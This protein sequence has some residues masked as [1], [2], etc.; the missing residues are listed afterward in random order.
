MIGKYPIIYRVSY[1]LGGA[2]FQPS[3]VSRLSAMNSWWIF[4]LVVI[5][6][7]QDSLSLSR[8]L[9]FLVL[10]THDVICN[11]YIY[12]MYVYIYICVCLY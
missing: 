6:K 9:Y 8:S 12:D 7:S 10:F 1:I 3:T 2:G 4:H 11:I 5:D